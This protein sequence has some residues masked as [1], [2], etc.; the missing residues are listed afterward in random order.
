VWFQ[1]LKA[2]AKILSYKCLQGGRIDS[3]NKIH[4]TLLSANKV[5][6]DSVELATE[7]SKNQVFREF[8]VLKRSN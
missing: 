7:F 1:H 5:E 6:R 8:D 3:V 4:K 2:S